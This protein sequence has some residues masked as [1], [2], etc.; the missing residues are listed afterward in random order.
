MQIIFLIYLSSTIRG[1]DTSAEIARVLSYDSRKSPKKSFLAFMNL[2]KKQLVDW[3]VGPQDMFHEENA[4]SSNNNSHLSPIRVNTYLTKL[5]DYSCKLTK[6]KLKPEKSMWTINQEGVYLFA[7]AVSEGIDWYAKGI[8]K[9]ASKTDQN[10]MA[11]QA[12]VLLSKLKFVVK[13]AGKSKLDRFDAFQKAFTPMPTKV[14]L[15]ETNDRH[16]ETVK[17]MHLLANNLILIA[18]AKR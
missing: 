10:L 12:S 16:S 3:P 7:L 18:M 6:S 2:S 9:T 17:G 4:S 13:S 1:A 5:Q 11:G 8:D 14:K 15:N